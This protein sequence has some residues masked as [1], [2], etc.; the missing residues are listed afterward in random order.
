MRLVVESKRCVDG[1]ALPDGVTLVGR[2]ASNSLMV[3]ATPG[4][5]D[6]LRRQIDIAVRVPER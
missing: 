4:A 5:A 6:L 1:G 3:E 2:I